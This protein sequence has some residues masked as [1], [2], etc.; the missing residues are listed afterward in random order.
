[1]PFP[2]PEGE[3]AEKNLMG[4]RGG[5]WLAGDLNEDPHKTSAVLHGDFIGETPGR[6]L[7]K[8]V[9]K[10]EGPDRDVTLTITRGDT[11]NHPGIAVD[12]II[13]HEAAGGQRG[14]GQIVLRGTLAW[15]GIVLTY[16]L[17]QY[18]CGTAQG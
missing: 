18:A 5:R 12:A 11:T 7:Q 6:I 16:K 10:L 15:V 1:M 9:G 4:F 3:G 17:L 2:S 13:A 14:Q 8:G